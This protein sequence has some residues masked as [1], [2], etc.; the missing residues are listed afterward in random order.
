MRAVG[1]KPSAKVADTGRMWTKSIWDR[2]PWDQIQAGEREG[3]VFFDDFLRMPAFA[4]LD[5]DLHLYATYSDTGNTIQQAADSEFGVLEMKTDATGGDDDVIITTGG[6]VGGMVKF[7]KRAT[8]VPHLIAFEC[9][10]N[11]SSI[12]TGA[13]FVGFAEEGL[14]SS[15]GLIQTDNAMENK[16]FLGFHMAGANA[17]MDVLYN[18]ES[19][20]DP[21]TV[22]TTA[23]TIVADT[24]VKWGLLYDYRSSNA[25]Q[26]AVYIDGVVQATYI[27]KAN[28]DVTA[29]FP[30][31]EEMAL[32]FA[33]KNTSAAANTF[34][35]DWWKWG[36][37]VLA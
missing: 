17:D 4:A 30:A 26:V 27:T 37:L 1:H 19:G 11:K 15:S 29:D 33:G 28:I 14:A 20:A 5:A 34:R 10:V 32:Y 25:Q 8:D 12:T 3:A 22:I 23:D 36:M 21:T 31:G 2:I 24:Y 6:N 9:R 18:K 13:M 16:D 7:I 35:M